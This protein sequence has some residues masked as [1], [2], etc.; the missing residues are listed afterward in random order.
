MGEIFEKGIPKYEKIYKVVCEWGELM[1][2]L[3]NKI[4]NQAKA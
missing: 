1:N 3:D 2:E 4:M